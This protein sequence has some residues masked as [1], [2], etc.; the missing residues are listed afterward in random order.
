M[1]AHAELVLE[2]MLAP[3][4]RAR[5]ELLSKVEAKIFNA[6]PA[7]GSVW[8]QTENDIIDNAI[9]KAPNRR[10]NFVEFTNQLDL[11]LPERTDLAIRGRLAKSLKA[12]GTTS[13]AYWSEQEIQIVNNIVN[14]ASNFTRHWQDG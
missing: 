8:P 7:T 10:T 1:R 5:G 9:T 2:A 3:Q 14:N 11:H 4:R 13:R 6:N 12:F